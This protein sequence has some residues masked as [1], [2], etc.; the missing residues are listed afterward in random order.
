MSCQTRTSMSPRLSAAAVSA[1][2]TPATV[3]S[4]TTS[5]TPAIKLVQEVRQAF[6]ARSWPFVRGHNLASGLGVRLTWRHRFLSRLDVDACSWETTEDERP[7]ASDCFPF[8]VPGLI[9]VAGSTVEH[10]GN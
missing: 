6:I 9:A 5:T 2:L 8:E 4:A 3:T 1:V 7:S 10:H